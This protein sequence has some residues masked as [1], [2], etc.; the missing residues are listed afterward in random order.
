[1]RPRIII[2]VVA[3]GAL[4]FLWFLPTL[5]Q[6]RFDAV[7]K[8]ALDPRPPETIDLSVRLEHVATLTNAEPLMSLLRAGRHVRNHRCSFQGTLGFHF[9]GGD[10]NG[11]A[12]LP[13]HTNANYEFRCSNGYFAVRRDAF[14]NTLALA[15][16]D[17]N[18]IPTK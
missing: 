2:P 4:A 7:L 1:M 16:V 13:G 17:T 15:G 5:M 12:I 18:R 10:S 9:S 3:F 14:M 6:P 8:P 11:V